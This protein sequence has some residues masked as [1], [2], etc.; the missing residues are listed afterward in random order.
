MEDTNFCSFPHNKNKNL[1]I[2]CV[3]DGH[4]GK[5]CALQLT[6]IFPQI[7]YKKFV[8]GKWEEKTD[9]S[10]LLTEVFHEVDEQLKLDVNQFLYEGS[11]GTTVIIWK[12]PLTSKRYVQ[13]ANIGDSTAF[14]I[15][16]GKSVIISEDHKLSIA[17]ERQRIIN[18]GVTLTSDQTRLCGLAV[19]RAFGDFFPKQEKC[20]IVCDP[21]VCSP[22]ELTKTDTTIILASDGLWDI[23]PDGQKAYDLIKN[24]KSSADAAKLLLRTA[25]PP[26]NNVCSDNVTVCVVSL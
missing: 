9:L 17:S 16:K 10:S 4:A 20:G 25:V 3:F 1:G 2:F 24:I 26:K 8:A 22:I 5:N 6:K 19:A 23:V 21:F 12:N 18:M 7:F 13:C 15:R 11:T 14:L